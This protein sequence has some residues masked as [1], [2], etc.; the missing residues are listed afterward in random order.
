ML[1]NGGYGSGAYLYSYNG[2]QTWTYS[3]TGHGML[4]WQSS[5]SHWNIIMGGYDRVGCGGWASGSTYWYDCV[6]AAGGPNGV[7]SPPTS[8]PFDLPL[9]TAAPTPA[10]TPRPT[11]VPHPPAGNGGSS[12]GS[13][14]GAGSGAKAS[15]A[16]A[17]SGPIA[18]QMWGIAGVE[19][20]RTAQPTATSAGA[21][22]AART[23][24][25]G[26][27]PTDGASGLAAAIARVIALVAGSAAVLLYGCSVFAFLRRRRR[28][29]A[30]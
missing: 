6:F 7:D 16:A 22:A 25:S 14:S 27:S 29:I 30:S 4:G 28:G 3:T 26:S 12:S 21:A 19:S 5:S 20:T 9:S 13:G 2:W 11:P 17:T 18:T 8:S 15:V 10:P 23:S 1:D 24:G